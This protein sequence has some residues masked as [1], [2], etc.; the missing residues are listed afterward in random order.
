MNAALYIKNVTVM[1]PAGFLKMRPVAAWAVMDC[2]EVVTYAK[3]AAAA[4][5]KLA[6]VEADRRFFAG[7]GESMFAGT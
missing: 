6:E 1:Q 2:G 3:T 4:R 5:E 7:A